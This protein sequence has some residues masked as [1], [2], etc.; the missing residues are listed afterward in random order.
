MVLAIF[1]AF[2]LLLLEAGN[3]LNPFCFKFCVK[4]VSLLR[5]S[6]DGLLLRS[7]PVQRKYLYFFKILKKSAL[8]KG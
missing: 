6:C 8:G 2:F 4:W 3:K 5:S 7:K 1:Y